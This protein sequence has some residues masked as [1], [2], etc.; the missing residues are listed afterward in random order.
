[1]TSR[2]E[3]GKKEIGKYVVT[4]CLDFIE[5][6]LKEGNAQKK[7]IYGNIKLE[8]AFNEENAELIDEVFSD[9]R[10]RPP[11]RKEIR[12]FR[13]MVKSMDKNK[14]KKMKNL[15]LMKDVL[16]VE[17]KEN[18]PIQEECVSDNK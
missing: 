13:K 3:L 11:S 12:R 18:E 2:I 14:N 17:V 15:K 16:P 5:V 8:K 7:H 9:L 1:M 4:K 10:K 6:K